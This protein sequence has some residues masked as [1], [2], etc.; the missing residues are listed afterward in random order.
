[1]TTTVTTEWPCDTITSRELEDLRAR[2]NHDLIKNRVMLCLLGFLSQVDEGAGIDGTVPRRLA[3]LQRA[4]ATAKAEAKLLE[5][6]LSYHTPTA[7]VL[8]LPFVRLLSP[9]EKA[10]IVRLVGH[11]GEVFGRRTRMDRSKE[12]R[13]VVS[14]ADAAIGALVA[15]S[16]GDRLPRRDLLERAR[17][18]VETLSARLSS[19]RIGE[20]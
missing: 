9:Y 20:C 1:M 17:L 7:D 6:R 14:S 8:G 3:D 10:A 19:H 4:W 18:E 13:R 11:D 16:A 15:S 5:S 12:W 2:L